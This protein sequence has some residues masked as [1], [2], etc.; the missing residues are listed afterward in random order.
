MADQAQPAIRE[1]ENEVELNDNQEVL[2]VVNNLGEEVEDDEDEPRRKKTKKTA[3]Y[4]AQYNLVP[5]EEGFD[6]FLR[7]F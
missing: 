2:E 6:G 3:P 5:D 7:Q 4:L 1:V